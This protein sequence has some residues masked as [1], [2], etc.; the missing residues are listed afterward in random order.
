MHHSRSTCISNQTMRKRIW[1]HDM[2]PAECKM[3]C[4]EYIRMLKWELLL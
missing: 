3:K 1:L 2:E 4:L